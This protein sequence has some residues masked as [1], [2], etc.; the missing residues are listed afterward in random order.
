MKKLIFTYLMAFNLPLFAEEGIDIYKV[1]E[2]Y[3]VS[4][5]SSLVLFNY[6]YDAIKT[7]RIKKF[8]IPHN[9]SLREISVDARDIYKM[10]R[11]EKFKIIKSHREG[12]I[13]EVKLLKIRVDDKHYKVGHP[14]DDQILEMK[15]KSLYSETITVFRNNHCLSI[16]VT[17]SNNNDLVF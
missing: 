3:K 2:V 11:G 16:M 15:N 17:T 5:H 13:Y 10:Q 4:S 1:G 12:K 7:E 8:G 9:F 14:A 6:K